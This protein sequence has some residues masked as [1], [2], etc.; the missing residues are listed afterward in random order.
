MDQRRLEAILNKAVAEHPLSYQEIAYLLSLD[1]P[2]YIGRVM[3]TARQMRDKYFGDKIFIYGFIYFSTYCRNHCSFCFYRRTNE[4]S[5][6]YRKTL[7]DV[8]T[9]AAGLADSGVH[10]IDLTM[11]EDPVI[12]DTGNFEVLY[13][14]INRVRQATDLPVMVSPGVVPDDVLHVFKDS[15]VDWYALYQETHNPKLYSKL[16]L[17][18]S[19]EERNYR[20]F[21]AKKL[22][23]LVEDGILLGAGEDCAD[24]ARSILA[25]RHSGVHQARVMSLVPQPRTPLAGRVMVPR[26]NEYLCIAVMRLAMPE[27]LIPASLDVDGIKGLKMRLAAGANVVTSIIPPSNSLAGVSQSSLD[28]E[29]GLRTVPEVKKILAE[30][31]LTAAG[32]DDYKGWIKARKEKTVE[33]GDCRDQVVL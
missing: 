30:I 14:M 21:T 16:R 6:R 3:D 12:H 13:E 1:N 26:I 23:M 11:G 19:Y 33:L 7:E 8:V 24:R 20:R 10:L 27:R 5:P 25:M 4:L 17:G 29:Q 22:G 2:V 15:G 28:I 9:I 32:A 18:Q 31:G